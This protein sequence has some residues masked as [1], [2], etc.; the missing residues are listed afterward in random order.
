MVTADNNKRYMSDRIDCGFLLKNCITSKLTA[1]LNERSMI[2]EIN[3]KF[4][5]TICV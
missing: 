5:L 4:L 3:R 2:D 1:D